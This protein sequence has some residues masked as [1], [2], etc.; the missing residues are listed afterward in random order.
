MNF[1]EKYKIK[2][3]TKKAEIQSINNEPFIAILK[4]IEDYKPDKLR[5]KFKSGNRNYFLIVEKTEEKIKSV[6]SILLNN[7]E[8]LESKL[9]DITGEELLEKEILVI[10]FFE[11][12]RKGKTMRIIQDF[13]GVN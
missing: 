5:F 13:Q 4:E 9:K 7:P 8:E 11:K 12:E 1:L 6:F 2:K 3:E 10:R